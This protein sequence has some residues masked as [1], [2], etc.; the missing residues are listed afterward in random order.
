MAKS[1]RKTRSSRSRDRKLV[2]GRQK[3]EVR[4]TAKKADAGAQS[5]TRGQFNGIVL[6][7]NKR[8]TGQ[9]SGFAAGSF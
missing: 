6:T 1:T 4:Y 8:V 7:R 5:D 3:P 9:I 2:A